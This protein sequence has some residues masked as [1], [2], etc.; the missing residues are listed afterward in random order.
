MLPF[1]LDSLTLSGLFNDFDLT[2]QDVIND[3]VSSICCDVFLLP[4]TAN[5]VDST[6]FL[7]LFLD[8]PC[9]DAMPSSFDAHASVL[10]L[11]AVVRGDR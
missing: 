11:V 4:E 7:D 5:D 3:P 6:A 1:D 8:I 10:R 2:G 9:S